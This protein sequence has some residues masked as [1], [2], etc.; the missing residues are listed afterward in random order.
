MMGDV[1]VVDAPA[2][3]AIAKMLGVP[4]GWSLT[5]LAKGYAAYNSG[6]RITFFENKSDF[7]EDE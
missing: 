1:V 7:E 2:A 5:K 3:D 6:D 4:D